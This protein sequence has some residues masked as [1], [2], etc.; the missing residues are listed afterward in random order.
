VAITFKA[1]VPLFNFCLN[2]DRPLVMEALLPSGCNCNPFG[3]F[4]K[5]GA[6]WKGFGFAPAFGRF[7]SDFK[8]FEAA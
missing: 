7:N 1:A 5:S 2:R 8:N 3:F 4:K 6:I